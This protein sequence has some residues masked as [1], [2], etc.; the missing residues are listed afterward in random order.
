MCDCRVL[1][2]K[3]GYWSDGKLETLDLQMYCH[4]LVGLLIYRGRQGLYC[5]SIVSGRV[6]PLGERRI[7]TSVGFAGPLLARP[8]WSHAIN[9]INDGWIGTPA[10]VRSGTRDT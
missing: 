8:T 9:V 6:Q 1:N 7:C 4:T 10:A 3:N 2:T 5:C